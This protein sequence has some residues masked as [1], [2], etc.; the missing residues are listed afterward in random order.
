MRQA[1]GPS[2]DSGPAQTRGPVGGHLNTPL[3]PVVFLSAI[4]FTVNPAQTEERTRPGGEDPSPGAGQ[5][6]QDHASET[7][8]V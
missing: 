3:I 4:G 1:L 2:P 8:G 6:R 5:C 7:A